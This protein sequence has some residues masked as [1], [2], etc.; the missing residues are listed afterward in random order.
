MRR[1]DFLFASL[2]ALTVLRCGKGS[3]QPRERDGGG[4]EA[5]AP[6]TAEPPH[7]AQT[8]GSASAGR[9]DPKAV[10]AAWFQGVEIDKVVIVGQAAMAGLRLNLDAIT[11]VITAE[12]DTAAA[13]AVLEQR[14]KADFEN[15]RVASVEGWLL[16]FT[17]A[18]MA[19]LATR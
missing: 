2:A 5:T 13:V 8:P 14:V 18:Y 10:V 16:S 6:A 3:G 11:A 7:P 19:G 4:G 1:R 15:G 12:R 17:E 9:A